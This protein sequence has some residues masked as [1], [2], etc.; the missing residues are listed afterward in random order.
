MGMIAFYGAKNTYDTLAQ[1][2]RS[3]SEAN[4]QKG[5]ETYLWKKRKITASERNDVK[6]LLLEHY[7]NTRQRFKVYFDNEEIADSSQS[8]FMFY[9]NDSD[10]YNLEIADKKYLEY[11]KTPELS[12][13]WQ[14][15]SERLSEYY[16]KDRILPR[17]YEGKSLELIVWEAYIDIENSRFIP[18]VC[19]IY[20]MDNNLNERLRGPVVSIKT[21]QGGKYV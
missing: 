16:D 6:S 9:F 10:N 17:H 14:T 5:I 18:I 19:E 2:D 1:D 11:F 13:Y 21:K 12:K 15:K 3:E 7:S 4:V 20:D 8:A